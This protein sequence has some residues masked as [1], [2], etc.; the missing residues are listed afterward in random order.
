M[1][2]LFALGA[3]AVPEPAPIVSH[4]HIHRTSIERSPSGAFFSSRPPVHNQ[5]DA[6]FDCGRWT[7]RIDAED[8]SKT[9]TTASG[10][11]YENRC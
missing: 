3:T 5:A 7:G 6:F 9:G 8:R 10:A 2:Y 4:G 11:E 1:T